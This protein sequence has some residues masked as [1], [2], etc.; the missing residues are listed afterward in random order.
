MSSAK[1]ILKSTSIVGGSQLIGIVFNLIRSKAVA[2][3]L[4]PAGVGLVSAFQSSL[5]LVQAL[6]GLGIENSAVR[7][8]AAANASDSKIDLAKSVLTLRRV[9]IITGLI[10]MGITI[11][12]APWISKAT[13]GTTEYAWPLRLLSLSVFFTILK[14]GQAALI[15]GLRRVKDLAKLSIFSAAFG[16]LVSIPFIY[17]M[18]EDGIPIYLVI[19]AVG[20]YIVSYYFSHKYKVERIKLSFKDFSL[21]ANQMVRLGLA[22]MGGG[23]AGLTGAYLIRVIIIQGMSLSTAG[24]YQAAVAISGLYINV[25]LQAMGKDFYPR[26]VSVAHDESKEIKTINDQIRVGTALA[27]PGLV[28]TLALAPFAIELLYT[29]EFLDAYKILQWMII[30]TFLRTMSWPIGY[31]FI[32]R[33]KGRHYFLIQLGSNILHILF[34]LL[35]IPVLGL[36]GTGVAFLAL[37]IIH[38]LVLYRLGS[39]LNGYKWD[40]GV[41]RSFFVYGS[42]VVAT[43]ITVSFLDV[44]YAAVVGVLLGGLVTWIALRDVARILEVNSFK[45]VIK[46]IF[47]KKKKK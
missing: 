47:K 11:L 23:L 14:G 37:Y 21:E 38:N 6:A 22:F 5:K 28:F 2:Y 27:A 29:S 16:T 10:G 40:N 8:I 24:I 1:S 20:Q 39:H 35:L 12:L 9:T 18:G 32:A 33:S 44:I 15:Q 43:F 41:R 31:L 7:S 34:V 45:G 42:V 4:G 25:V 46:S 3:L 13:F 19:L 30:G 26:L 17:F 36:E